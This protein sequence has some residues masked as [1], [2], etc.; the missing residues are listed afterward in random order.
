MKKVLL[1]S[2][3]TLM[4]LNLLAQT[5]KNSWMIGGSAGFS[6]TKQ[7]GNDEKSTSTKVEFS[8]K[9]GYFIC[10]DFAV[11]LNLDLS[12]STQGLSSSSYSGYGLFTRYYYP[13][14]SKT[15]KVFGSFDMTFLNKTENKASFN[16]TKFGVGVGGVYFPSKTVGIETLV[17]YSLENASQYT[18]QVR[19]IGVKIGLQVH[20]F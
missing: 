1:I 4:S 13:A 2:A 18:D 20:L 11:G 17:G 8:P 5:A 16:S 6:S 9:V 15:A 19:E 14:K 7:K 3:I 10:N 12:S